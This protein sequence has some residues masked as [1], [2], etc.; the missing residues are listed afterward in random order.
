MLI[1]CRQFITIDPIES[2]DD[3]KTTIQNDYF[4]NKTE[5]QNIIEKFILSLPAPPSA[6]AQPT[7]TTSTPVQ[8]NNSPGIIGI[9]MARLTVLKHKNTQTITQKYTECK[10]KFDELSKIILKLNLSRKELREYDKQFKSDVPILHRKNSIFSI[11]KID[12]VSQK[13][14]GCATASLE[15]CF[16]AFRVLLC[17]NN[18][19]LINHLSQPTIQPTSTTTTTTTT[20]ATTPAPT[21][22]T[23]T[24]NPPVS[25]TQQI[26]PNQILL[27]NH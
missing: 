18:H 14:Y 25:T 7:Q 24:I 3:R 27:S 13:C 19:Q 10:S 15:H 12:N 23:T 9:K 2:E 21:K 1:G 16:N 17:S 8:P 5:E 20:T 11:N 22:T 26:Q 6:P 4:N